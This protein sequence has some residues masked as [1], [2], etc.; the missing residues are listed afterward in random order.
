MILRQ[1]EIWKCKP[2][3]FQKA[4]WFVVISG[5]ERCAEQKQVSINGLICF[6]LRGSAQKVDV[7]LDSAEGFDSATVCQCDYF[8]VL[9]KSGLFDKIG[10][11]GVERQRQIKAKI[12]ELLRLN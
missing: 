3:G 8:Y 6:T 10:A 12:R 4:H 11:V 7:I 2:E 5:M 1:F 9:P